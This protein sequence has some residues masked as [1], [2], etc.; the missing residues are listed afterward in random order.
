MIEEIEIWKDVP[1]YEGLYQVSSFGNV[2]SLNYRGNG[3]ENLLKPAL[4]KC[5]YLRVALYK[6]S[7]QN[8]FTIHIL[9]AMAFYGHKPDG[10]NKICVDHIDNIKTNNRSDNLQ[11]ISN[12]ENGSKDKKG[13]ASIFVGVTWNKKSKKWQACIQFNG[14]IINL[15]S[16]IIEI[17]ANYAYQKALKE[18][19]DG[20]DLNIVY[21]KGRNNSS[22]YYG[23]SFNKRNGK[24]Q[25]K[26]KKKHIGLFKTELEAHQAV[27][28]YIA[29][30]VIST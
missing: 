29:S 14:R 9:V 6:N 19:N 26:Y 17:D 5:G 7:N 11:L 22:K 10:T 15:G 27:Q 3:K 16:F 4:I 18:I 8:S 12:R 21:P 30:L 23:V 13:G 28:N 2:K 24:W 25:A 1:N 20:F